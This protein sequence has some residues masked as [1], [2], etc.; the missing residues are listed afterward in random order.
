MVDHVI[1]Y[2]GIAPNR[3]EDTTDLVVY[4]MTT[5]DERFSVS[6]L[7]SRD[8]ELSGRLR[9]ADVMAL[10]RQAALEEIEARLAAGFYPRDWDSAGVRT[11]LTYDTEE[12]P[13]L[14]ALL[15]IP[16]GC[17]WLEAAEP[18]GHVC[19]ATRPGGFME[20]T[21]ALC[22]AC[23]MPDTSLVCEALVFPEVD[24]S[25]D[26][27][28]RSRHI[29]DVQ[30]EADQSI[31]RGAGCVPGGKECWRRSITTGRPT[32]H[33]DSSA[34]RRVLDEIGYL[35]LVYADAFSLTRSEAEA[36][37]PMSGEGA[38]SSLRDPCR[39]VTDFRT[40]VVTLCE[41]LLK[42]KPHQ[43]LAED[44]RMGDDR[45]VNGITALQ[46]VLEDRFAGAARDGAELLR[47]LTAARNR[48]SHDD[49]KELLAALRALGVT[50]YPPQSTEVAWWQVAASV[51]DAL[52]QIRSAMQSGAP[53]EVPGT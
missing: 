7:A 37:W 10:L 22:G 9:G 39:T 47:E 45:Q 35:R 12:V 43:Q 20:T 28:G 18:R 42:M 38:V 19:T 53:S 13:V 31:G 4:D 51:A 33:S 46:R 26:S 48:F 49:R 17:L 11:T 16:K 50:S 32:S 40:R 6:A 1:T 8:A 14:E 24:A 29:M 23:E 3:G 2:R 34:P 15:D 36:F 30:C 21:P 52:G 5:Q 44:R 25:L 27:E 41:I